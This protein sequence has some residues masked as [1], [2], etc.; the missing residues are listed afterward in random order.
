[1]V[2]RFLLRWIGVHVCWVSIMKGQEAG[3]RQYM[4]ML[5]KCA[6]Q[7]PSLGYAAKGHSGQW[8]PI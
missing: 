1:M 2:D 4:W 5:I 6:S 3:Y 7:D 8:G